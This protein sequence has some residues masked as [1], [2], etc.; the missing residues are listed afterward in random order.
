M[1][2]GF[3]EAERYIIF[4]IALYNRWCDKHINVESLTGG[5]PSNKKGLYR[6]AVKSLVRK[7]YP[8][9]YNSQGRVDVCALKQYRAF[10]ILSLQ[11]HREEHR[12]LE[13]FDEARIR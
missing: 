4:K 2:C 6:D 1:P 5:I 3:T 12:F 13:R 8:K 11:G 10:I 7:G 9:A